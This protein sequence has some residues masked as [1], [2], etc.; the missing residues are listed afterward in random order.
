MKFLDMLL[1]KTKPI[2]EE[3]KQ[4]SELLEAPEISI[5][6]HE[7]T[8]LSKKKE[9]LERCVL[10]RRKLIELIE[11]NEFLSQT[12]RAEAELYVLSC[13]LIKENQD[14]I[15]KLQ[16]LLASAILGKSEENSVILVFSNAEK[17]FCVNKLISLYTEFL[18]GNMLSVK[19]LEDN[20]LLVEGQNAKVIA[21]TL[22]GRHKLYLDKSTSN[23]LVYS[24]I[25]FEEAVPQ[26][27]EKNVRID[28]FLS[29][30]KGG[31][32]INK[33]E[34]AVRLTYLPTGLQVTCQDERSQLKNKERAFE[35]LKDILI[36]QSK[37]KSDSENAKRESEGKKLSAENVRTIDFNKNTLSDTRTN[38]TLEARDDISDQL[39][40]LSLAL[41]SEI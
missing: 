5:D 16:I 23:P 13:R 41:L 35:R 38:I 30:G 14:A 9:E 26:L 37:E 7:S 21:D 2:E 3:Y 22:C 28:I 20:K 19:K 40:Q 11:E 17:D 10:I 12:D 36:D 1:L 15:N 24:Y 6:I 4:I 29:H 27:N 18:Q 25:P 39:V 31:Q 34:T 33:V 8:A 32:N